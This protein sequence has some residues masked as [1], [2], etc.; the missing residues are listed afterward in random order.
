MIYVLIVVLVLYIFLPFIFKRIKRNQEKKKLAI[1]EM[2]RQMRT[3]L[4]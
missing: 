4:K 2:E 1:K 3:N